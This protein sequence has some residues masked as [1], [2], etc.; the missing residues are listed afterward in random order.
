MKWT[1]APAAVLHLT[2]ERLE[3]K[4]VKPLLLADASGNQFHVF[5]IFH[6]LNNQLKT[7][8][9]ENWFT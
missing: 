7:L 4:P 6:H 9:P 2:L 1:P 3:Q 5:F 8:R